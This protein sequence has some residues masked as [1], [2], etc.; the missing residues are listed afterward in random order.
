M[1]LYVVTC[2]GNV[3]DEGRTYLSKSNAIN[4]AKELSLFRAIKI[5]VASLRILKRYK[6]EKGEKV[7]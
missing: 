1:T 6:F 4:R 5:E 7:K 2:G 3:I